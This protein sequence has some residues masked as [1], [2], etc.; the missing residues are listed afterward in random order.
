MALKKN[1]QE[2]YTV[3]NS[4]TPNIKKS[5][6]VSGVAEEA[7]QAAVK[8][9]AKDSS[10]GKYARQILH[11]AASLKDIQE[12]VGKSMHEYQN[13]GKSPKTMKWLHRAAKSIIYYTNVF[14]VFVPQNPQ[15]VSLAWGAMRFLFTAA[16][17]HE[18]T[19][20][21]L[22]KS[23]AQ[24]AES[25]PRMHLSSDL[26]P[27][28]QMKVA[29][30]ELYAS[31]LNFLVKAYEWYNE[32]KLSHMFHGV[33]QQWNRVNADLVDEIAEKSRRI[34]QLAA[35]ASQAE[36]R[37]MHQV[38]TAIRSRLSLSDLKLDEILGKMDFKYYARHQPISQILTHLSNV[39][40]DDPLKSF[41]HH[42][43]FRKRRAQGTNL[44]A[45]TNPFWLSSRFQ[46]LFSTEDSALALMKGNFAT[47]QVLQDFCV[48]IIEH[49]RS[50]KVPTLWALK[51]VA[52]PNNEQSQLSIVDLL[53]YLVFQALQLNESLKTE[54]T[55]AWRCAQF[56]R[57]TTAAELFQLL[58]AALNGLGQQ[59]YLVIDLETIEESLQS[60]DGFNIVS[61]FLQSF[62]TSPNTRLK[63]IIVR[64][65][66]N[67]SEWQLDSDAALAIVPV[68]AIGRGRQ[69]GKEVRQKVKTAVRRGMMRQKN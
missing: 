4:D 60:L 58:L 28:P 26:Y 19:T 2:W 48:D 37:D 44:S 68:R 24:I 25:L 35:T 32:G 12:A 18:K 45:V 1:F 43:F 49:L 67:F 7:F 6:P 42:L 29:L 61:A 57:A 15:Y 66:A 55:M 69:Q 5:D 9:F 11:N 50:S 52:T 46:S 34:D 64:Y 54:K 59:V 8:Q 63:I 65:R 3:G 38:V 62:H 47:R 40:L 33:S 13:R 23:I 53:K 36:L 56:Q 10:H 41:Q 30:E 27:T 16:V 31:V 21:L 20:Q 51:K 39:P 22:A 14:D 17:E